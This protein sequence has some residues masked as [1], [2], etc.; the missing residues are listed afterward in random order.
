[1]KM[2]QVKFRALTALDR[3]GAHPGAPLRLAAEE[4]PDR[5]RALVIRVPSPR[6]RCAHS[7][8][9]RISRDDGQAPRPGDRAIVTITMTGEQAGDVL[10]AGQRS[11]LWRAGD[12][13]SGVIPRRVCT[14][15]SPC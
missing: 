6:P 5:A 10:D 2:P 13:G 3:A 11:A 15:G 8:P 12:A 14:D 7:F 9:S 1:M 4:F